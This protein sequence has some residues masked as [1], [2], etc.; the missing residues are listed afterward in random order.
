M[1]R[2]EELITFVG[3]WAP[4]FWLKKIEDMEKHVNADNVVS[5]VWYVVKCR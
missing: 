1:K 2:R 3:W 4:F 5:Y